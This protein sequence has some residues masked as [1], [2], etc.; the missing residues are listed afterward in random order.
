MFAKAGLTSSIQDFKAPTDELDFIL[1]LRLLLKISK[2]PGLK[3]KLSKVEVKVDESKQRNSRVYGAESDAK[4]I[5]TITKKLKVTTSSAEVERA[6]ALVEKFSVVLD[7]SRGIVAVY[8]ELAQLTHSCRLAENNY[9]HQ[10][11]S[12]RKI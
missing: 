7:G 11:S 9:L 6:T 10:R 5:D 2:D 8:V 3:E 1:P 4:I 12:L